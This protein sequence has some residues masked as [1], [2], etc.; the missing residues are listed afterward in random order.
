MAEIRWTE[1]AHRWL[2]DIHDYIA[3]D[4]PAAAQRVVSG[5]YDKAQMLRS[6]PEIGQRYRAEAEGGN[7]D[8]SLWA[9]SDCL[10]SQ[11]TIQYRYLGRVPR[12]T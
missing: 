7:Q 6:F 3:A 4:N 5:I 11:V 12:G 8:P 9:L 2:R 1:E 10:S